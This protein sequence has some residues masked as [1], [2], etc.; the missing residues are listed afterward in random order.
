MDGIKLLSLLAGVLCLGGAT[1]VLELSDRFLELRGDSKW[2]V[3]FYAPW[4]GHC[5][6][7]EP[8]WNHVAHALYGTDIRVGRVDCTRF[9][10]VAT[11][12]TIKG[13]P[14]ILYIQGDERHMY[15]GDRT[16]DEIVGFGVRMSAPAVQHLDSHQDLHDTVTRDRLFFL[17][18]G[19]QEGSL[20]ESYKSQADEMRTLHFFYHIGSDCMEDHY[21]L[22]SNP[23]VMVFKDNKHYYFP[24]PQDTDNQT[25]LNNTLADW[26][27]H[28]RFFLYPKIT[29]GN[30]A[31]LWKLKKYL[32]ITV[33]KES[34]IGT[35]TTD[36]D[37][38][39]YVD[40]YK[41]KDMVESVIQNNRE[42]YHN[43]FQFGWTGT[44]DLANSIAMERLPLPS[45]LVVNA[46]TLHHHMPEDPAKHLTPEAI[47]LFL[48][49][50]L[51]Q[52]APAYGGDSWPVRAF[53]MYY[54][55]RS[56]LEDMWLGN[57]VLTAVLFGLPLGF[58]SLICYSIWCSDI[59]DADDEEE[60]H[61]EKKE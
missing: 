29:H 23:A 47:Q 32:V 43:H 41:F 4:C 14:T 21:T 7:L 2:L 59:L 51:A 48:D 3:M 15:R 61:H 56:S 25:L 55:A 37:V 17:Y 46:T 38:E 36:E 26:L 53:R 24:T 40:G 42:K 58:L 11:E 12:F 13:F 9:T 60:E 6:K 31:Q 44:P 20:W 54:N 50:V 16:K 1:K 28:E 10:A 5:K 52:N 27:N 8:I 39:D 19:A 18:A 34:K 22:E 33:V 57:P 45:L 35:I 30:L 49:A